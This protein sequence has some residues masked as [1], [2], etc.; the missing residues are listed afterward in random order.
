VIAIIK[1]QWSILIIVVIKVGSGYSSY[2]NS[3]R[4]GNNNCRSSDCLY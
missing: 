2:D 3:G 1:K 4:G